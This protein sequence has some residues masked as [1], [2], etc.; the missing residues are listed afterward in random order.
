MP[1]GGRPK[2]SRDQQYLT[3]AYWFGVI[4]DAM[5]KLSPER[6]VQI[7]MEVVK[8]MAEK[9]QMPAVDPQVPAQLSFDEAVKT[10]AVEAEIVSLKSDAPTGNTGV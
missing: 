7:G 10:Q 5:Q 1:G 2:G 9:R 4:N 3:F 8:L 6:Q